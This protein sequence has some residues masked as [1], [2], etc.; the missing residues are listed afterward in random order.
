MMMQEGIVDKKNTL[1]IAGLFLIFLSACTA[2]ELSA[3]NPSVTPTKTMF[4]S[5]PPTE[6]VYASTPTSINTIVA[7]PSPTEG[8]PPDLELL[9]LTLRYR[10]KGS[11]L[12]FGEIR[13]NT[14]TAMVF[15]LN[16]KYRDIPILRFQKKAWETNGVL[17]SYWFSD[18][19]IGR[20]KDEGWHTSC[21]LYPGEIGLFYLDSFACQNV[22]DTECKSDSGIIEGVP[23]ATGLQLVGYQDLKTYIPWPDLYTGYH[24]QVENLEF[25]VTEKRLEFGFDLPKKLFDPFYDFMI[26]VVVYDKDGRMLGILSHPDSENIVV[27]NGG[28]TYHIAGFTPTKA[29]TDLSGNYFQGN[30]LDED[31][32]RIDHLQVMVE[33]QHVYLCS[34]NW[35][36]R[37]REWVKEHP[38]YSGA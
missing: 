13:N 19:K 27:D 29:N 17:T 15:P 3:G 4:P 34:Y 11:G 35:Y 26:W 16:D 7:L 33:M 28:D 30:M 37:Y 6:T 32:K 2:G 24:P 31:F 9:N 21:F 22:L 10:G 14:D 5:L 8:P 1:S 20:G 12:L 23:E 38:E 36:D 25:T 18:F